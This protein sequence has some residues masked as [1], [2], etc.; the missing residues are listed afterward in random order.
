[1]AARLDPRKYR[2]DGFAKPGGETGQLS[3][4]GGQQ[5]FDLSTNATGEERGGSV[6]LNS[7]QDGRSFN[8]SRKIEA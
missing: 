7:D 8:Q 6:R 4:I 1:M 2:G 5:N 3:Q